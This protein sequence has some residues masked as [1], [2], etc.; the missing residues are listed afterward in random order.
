MSLKNI[1]EIA[2]MAGI[3]RKYVE[4]YGNFMAK[5][6]LSIMNDLKSRRGK[7]ILVTAMTPT[8]AGEGKTTTSIGLSMAINRIGKKSILALRE[9]SLG[10]VFGVKGGATGGGKSTVQPMEEINLHFTGDFHAI[11]SAHN[12]LSAMINNHIYY[13]LEPHIDPKKVIWRRTID[14]NDRALRQIIVGLGRGNGVIYEDGFDIVPASEIMAIMALSENYADLKARLSKIIVGFTKDKKP[15]TAKDIKATGSMAALLKNALKPNLVQTAENTPAFVHIGPFGNIAHGTNS[16]IADKLG[17]ALSDY[18]VTEAG[19]GSDLGAEKFF[20][21]VTRVGNFKPNAVVVVASIRAMKYHGGAK[22]IEEENVEAMKKGYDNLRFH[23]NNIRKFGIDPVVAINRFPKDTE[24]EISALEELLSEDKTTW[25]LSEVFAKGGEGGE[26]LAKKVV[27]RAD[28]NPE[29]KINYT[30]DIN[31]PVEIKIEKIA[32][33]VYGARG[34]IFTKDAE[35]DLKT[36][37]KIGMD[38][39]FVCM[40]KTQSSISDDSKALNVPRDFTVTVREIKI[41][42]GANF[43]VPILGE[44]MRMPGLSKEPA[45]YKIDLLDDGTIVGLF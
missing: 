33:N 21:I 32:K 30:Y 18:F 39:A 34:V 6:N 25:S 15:V 40:A 41:S 35:E 20:N 27:Q 5:I 1:L 17:L 23:V 10:P 28:S 14:M 37:K 8:P 19:F 2:D 36:I 7:M 4:Q 26:D 38:N 3:D 13:D 9:P 43:V 11:S 29:P 44:I 42:A 24:K 12:L 31:D 16:I 45:A 22:N